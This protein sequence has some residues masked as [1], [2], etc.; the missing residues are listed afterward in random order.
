[1][2]EDDSKYFVIKQ[3]LQSAVAGMI[4][5]FSI[6]LKH[7]STD[8]KLCIKHILVG[9]KE[10]CYCV[11][12]ECFKSVIPKVGDIAPLGE[13]WKAGRGAVGSKGA[14]GVRWKIT[15]HIGGRRLNTNID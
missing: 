4:I 9:K 8:K 13:G 1:M 10:I 3:W 6:C 14:L 5:T 7:L 15:E 12:V 11:V 2:E